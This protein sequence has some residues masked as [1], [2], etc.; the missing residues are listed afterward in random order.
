MTEHVFRC[1]QAIIED[2]EAPGYERAVVGYAGFLFTDKGGP[3]LVAI[4]WERRFNHMAKRYNDIYRAQMP[5]I[6]PHVRRHPAA[7][8][9]QSPA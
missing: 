9:W 8:A 6:T 1:F 2:W 7:A 3:P 5:N 4:H